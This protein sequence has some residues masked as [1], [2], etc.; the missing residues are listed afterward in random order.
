[1]AQQRRTN[2]NQSTSLPSFEVMANG[3]VLPE[4]L[5]LLSLNTTTELNKISSATLYFADGDPA[6]GTFPISDE[7]TLNPGVEIEI[8]LGYEGNN[9]T[10]FTGLV[11]KQR[12]QLKED[13]SILEVKC[14]DKTFALTQVQ[15]N[16]VWEEVTDS[17]VIEE[18]ANNQDISNEVE[19]TSLTHEK[20]VQYASTNWDFI[21]SRAEANGLVVATENGELKIFKPD[22]GQSAA[23]SLAY[24]A[25]ILEMDTELD[26]S[27]VFSK[28]KKEAWSYANQESISKE[29]D[30]ENNNNIGNVSASDVASA[31]AQQENKAAYSNIYVQE[32]LD[33]LTDGALLRA[34]L[35]RIKGT[36][37]SQGFADIQPGQLL[38]LNGVGE[39]YN[40][41]AFVSGVSHV[42]A[43]G[44]WVSAFQL[45]MSA[46]AHLEKFDLKPKSQTVL[47]VT[48]GLE[49][50]TVIELEQDPA[51]EDR[52]KIKIPNF[53]E[54]G[55]GIWARIAAPDAG[56]NRGFFF[57]PEIE[58]EVIVG[59][60]NNDP[61]SP[62]VLGMLNSSAKPAPI[63]ASND[64]HEK[65]II[66][67]SEMKILFN[68]D[69]K[70]IVIETPAGNKIKLS[71]EDETILIEDQSG[72]KLEMTSDGILIDSS[73]D[74]NIK[75][76]GDLTL[77]GTNVTITANAEFKAS[78]SAGAE[79]S[80]SAVAVLK[81]SLV[82]IN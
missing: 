75:S 47:P 1:M 70:S 24:G 38:E 58:D 64:N 25:T 79:L 74:V 7:S 31:L 77:E 36:V 20:L 73:S 6:S 18:I 13:K 15:N 49:Y 17:D 3:V 8:K 46:E 32:E 2:E 54:D 50:A 53:G 59:F 48:T 34:E 78:G 29:A 60:V 45:G 33:A 40:G 68:D 44:N 62:I 35:S 39:K 56:E 14:K 22:L 72:N 67:R 21:V 5:Q 27:N 4:Q 16:K 61:R 11:I 26:G 51:G 9:A 66:T 69:Q 37:K 52:I 63:V 80:T 76:S 71:E 28:E 30:V 19:S 82:Q 10:V 65:G 23:L 41:N 12:I 42:V 57:R 55:N 43:N 81:G